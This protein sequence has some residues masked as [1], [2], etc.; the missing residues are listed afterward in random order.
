MPFAPKR[1]ALLIAATLIVSAC[2]GNSAVPPSASSPSQ[3]ITTPASN[4]VT[5]DTVDMTSVLKKLRK[6]VVIGST[7]DTKNHDQ[8]PRAISIVP[9]NY[10]LKKGQLLVCNFADSSG[11]AGNGTTIEVLN[12]VAGSKPKRFAQSADLKGCSGDQISPGNAVYGAGLVSGSLAAFNQSGALTKNYTGA[13]FG[14]PFSDTYVQQPVLYAPEYIFT[15]DVKAG[16]LISLNIGIASD[17]MAPPPL[18]VVNGFDVNDIGPAGQLGPSGLQYNSKSDTLYAVDGVDNTVIAISHASNLLVQ[19]E[20]TV[21]PGGKT[22]TCKHPSD[23]CATLVYSGS[24]LY[25]PMAMAILPNGNLIVANTKRGNKLVELTSTGTVL[26]T[27]VVDNA[28][29]A[30]VFGLLAVGTNDSNTVLYYT[31]TNSNELIELEK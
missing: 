21:Q 9:A 18:E 11:V 27:K 10:G 17:N 2:S 5:T 20:I 4:G 7:V 28:R 25:G 22:F 12:N 16:T 8:A 6:T 1:A 3:D 26:A 15:S 24:P 31:D 19:D 29:K 23:T 30:A 14:E 13:P